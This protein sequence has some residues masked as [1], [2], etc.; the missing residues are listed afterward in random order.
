MAYETDV[1]IIGAGP[2]GLSAVEFVKVAGATCIV[3]DVNE[4]RLAFC[5]ERM[6]VVHTIVARGDGAEIGRASCR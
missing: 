6:G 4:G 2:I 1:L 5:R 3:M